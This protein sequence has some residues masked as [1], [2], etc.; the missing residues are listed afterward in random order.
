MRIKNDLSE[1]YD[2]TD[3]MQT[4][5]KSYRMDLADTMKE[6]AQTYL[7]ILMKNTDEHYKFGRLSN[8]WVVSNIAVVG[9]NISFEITNTAPYASFVN[10]GWFHQERFVPGY[11]G[12]NAGKDVF[13]YVPNH[14]S[15][16]VFKD[17]YNEGTFFMELSQ[18]EIQDRLPDILQ[19]SFLDF[20]RRYQIG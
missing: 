16:V 5:A 10:D 3:K 18:L 14:G 17:R 11:W 13:Y 12:T 15:G 6:I 2:F 20:V 1:L 8:S 19:D 9:R 4:A 7:D